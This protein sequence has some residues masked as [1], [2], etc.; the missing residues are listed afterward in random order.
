[1]YKRKRTKFESITEAIQNESRL[2]EK[3]KFESIIEVIQ[4]FLMMF[5][6]IVGVVLLILEF[7]FP[8]NNFGNWFLLDFVLGGTNILLVVDNRM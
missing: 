2:H 6:G 8:G 1:M 4:I 5:F 3:T 7:V